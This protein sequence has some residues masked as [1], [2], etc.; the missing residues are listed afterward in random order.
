MRKYTCVK[1][2]LIWG[3]AAMVM[4]SIQSIWPQEREIK[5][6]AKSLES[7]SETINWEEFGLKLVNRK[8]GRTSTKLILKDKKNKGLEVNYSESLLTKASAQTINRLHQLFG[9]GLHFLVRQERYLVQEQDIFDIVVRPTKLECSGRDMLAYLPEDVFFTYRTELEYKFRMKVAKIFVPIH[10]FF[11][12]EKELCHKLIS[13]IKNPEAYIERRDPEFLKQRLDLLQHQLER[14]ALRSN[15]STNAILALET[16]GW[17]S[18]PKLLARDL[19]ELVV[20]LKEKNPTWDA[21]RIDQELESKQ[22]ETST[23][24]IRLILLLYFNEVEN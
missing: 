12:T 22:V 16:E 1:I 8:Q 13:A 15:Q 21:E 3:M 19:I 4:M 7:P 5:A 11:T 14:L 23:K 24:K 17:F 9:Q 20:G 6:K 2:S 18:G 10:G